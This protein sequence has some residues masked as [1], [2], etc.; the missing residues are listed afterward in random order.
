MSVGNEVLKLLFKMYEDECVRG[1]VSADEIR[2]ELNKIKEYCRKIV[3]A[4][5][6]DEA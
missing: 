3:S 4:C 5:R 6:G 1:G 2:K